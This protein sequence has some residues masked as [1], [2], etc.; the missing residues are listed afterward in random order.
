MV[1][2]ALSHRDNSW[3]LLQILCK[4]SQEANLR[5]EMWARSA[6]ARCYA[7][8]T[9][10]QAVAKKT[11]WKTDREDSICG[12]RKVSFVP[13]PLQRQDGGQK[14]SSWVGADIHGLHHRPKH[15]D[16]ESGGK[17]MVCETEVSGDIT[18]ILLPFINFV[19]WW[20]REH[21]PWM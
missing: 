10:K 15:C 6:V 1:S 7:H 3:K 19:E 16:I 14:L 21:K 9:L 8:S 12:L 4:S 18:C 2:K 20:N 17:P 13:S 11:C 5:H